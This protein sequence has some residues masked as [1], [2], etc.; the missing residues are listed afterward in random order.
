MA[1]AFGGNWLLAFA[2]VSLGPTGFEI[3]ERC[4]NLRGLCGQTADIR[5]L[6]LPLFGGLGDGGH[7]PGLASPQSCQGSQQP[8][9][10]PRL[11]ASTRSRKYDAMYV[12][13]RP[14]VLH[15]RTLRKSPS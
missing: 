2:L 15:V 5:M 10:L 4:R 8:A 9:K 14:L 12:A 3:P 11:A 7:K 1:S 13:L 6:S